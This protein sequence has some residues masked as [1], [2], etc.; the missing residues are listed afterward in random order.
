MIQGNYGTNDDLSHY[1]NADVALDVMS[2]QCSEDC[3]MMTPGNQWNDALCYTE[4]PYILEIKDICGFSEIANF[5]CSD[6]D[7]EQMVTFRVVDIFGNYNDCMVSVNVQDKVAPSLICPAHT[8]VDCDTA[9]DPQN[10]DAIYGT[11]VLSDDCGATVTEEGINELSNCNL[12][13]YT[14]LFT[15]T[16]NG[17]RSS[18]CKQVLTF[19][20]PNSFNPYIDVDCPRDTTIIGCMAPEDLSPDVMGYPE[21]INERCGLL[22]TDWDDEIYTFNNNQGDA[23]FKILRRWEIIDW[24][25]PTLPVWSCTQVIKVTNGDKPI[26]FGCED[27]EICTFDSECETGFIEL[28]V[29]ATDS[30]TDDSNLSW[31]YRV[32]QGEL[33]EG[34]KYFTHPIAE[35]TG[36]GNVANASGEY[37]VGTHIVRW[38]FFD[39]CGNA[40]S[41][42]QE[43]TIANCKAPTAYCINGLAVDLMPMDLNGDGESDFAM[44]ELWASDFDA[45]SHH[46][47]GYEV[48]L[49]FSGDSI[50][51][52][53][54]FDCTTRGDQEVNIW[55]SI[56]GYDGTVIQSY[57]TSVVNVQDNNNACQGQIDVVDVG[58]SIFTEDLENMGDVEVKLEGSNLTGMTNDNGEYAFPDMPMGGDYIV[59]PKHD[60]DHLNGVSTLDIIEIQRHLLGLEK[61]ESPYKLIAADVNRDYRISTIDLLELR[62]L[63]LG[64]YDD[65]PSNESWRF[66]DSAYDFLDPLNPLNED[67]K[68]AYLISKLSEDMDIDFVAVKVGD[69][70]DNSV[71]NSLGVPNEI[72]ESGIT[73]LQ[74]DDTQ[75]E[76]GEN[77]S[78]PVKIGNETLR[79]MQLT[80]GYNPQVLDV[81]SIES[82][83]SDFN[84]KNYRI[85]EDYI[86]I[87]WNTD[88]DH[89]SN[90]SLFEI[91]AIAKSDGNVMNTI[92]V[93]SDMLKA[94]SYDANGLIKTPVIKVNKD[95]N[96]GFK[97]EQN[98]PNP[99]T[100]YTDVRF[101]LEQN[102][103]VDIIVSDVQ[104]RVVRNIH[105]EFAKGQNS[106]RLHAEDLGGSGVYY[107]TLR[108]SKQSSTI[109]MVVLR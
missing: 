28:E 76:I 52:N 59:R 64:I 49:S 89:V 55:A 22:G 16:D 81:T 53:M 74:L 56:V 54:V 57:C 97:L 27:K 69:V 17:G 12:G 63:I 88:Q 43:F 79:G 70:N 10:L 7:E 37:P 24:C 19:V 98:T 60:K 8:T 32:Y 38:T 72:R 102:E 36:D 71:A 99:F 47:C 67:F 29:T 91:K 11:P 41:C 75:F 14:R 90:T 77:V 26:I 78:I 68:E 73:E 5:C 106:Y 42:D 44:V 95:E 23:C 82:S 40:T 108:T 48:T 45:G 62:K 51:P 58:G 84:S 1:D 94:E 35:D 2:Q 103:Q 104:G 107:L 85:A 93:A 86:V 46:P 101:V 100:D 83:L 39:R 96:Q 6:V 92:N 109:K 33:G 31:R 61:I 66:I 25:Q 3:V 4:I 34:P 80:L 18:T 50:V 9:F 65:F 30:C 13:T 20:N 105:S 87:S 15:A 21:F